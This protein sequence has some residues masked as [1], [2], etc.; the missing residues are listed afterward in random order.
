MTKTR[1]TKSALISSVVALLLCFA[2][3]V[4]STF[5]WFTDSVTS[6]NNIIKSGTLDVEM[7]WAEGTEDPATA[8]WEDASTTAIFDYDNWEP[9]YVDVKHVKISNV[10]TL[11][12]KYIVN[13]KANGEVSKLAE[14]IDVYF[15]DPAIQVSDRSA[16][17]DECKV[18]T[19]ADVLNGKVAP[20][21][22]DL[23]AAESDSITIALKMQE[24]AGNEYQNLS[25]GTN[26]SVQVLATQLASE[27]DSFNGEYDAGAVTYVKYDAA[28]T[29]A[30]NATALQ[31]A[32]D[33]ANEGDI[34]LLG[35]GNWYATQYKQFKINTDGVTLVGE[36][37]AVLGF[38]AENKNSILD[39]H[40][41]NVTIRN[42]E[43]NKNKQEFNQCILAIGAENL[44]VDSCTFYGENLDGGNTP[45]IGIY[46]FENLDMASDEANDEVTK[47]T[48]TNNNFLGAA[49]GTYKGGAAKVTTDPGVATAQVS[50]D[51]VIANNVFVG[52]N[53]LIENW[54]SWSKECTR[55]HEFVPTIE[56]NIFESPNLC[57][58]NTPHSIYLR[59][60]RQ[61]DPDK[62]LPADYMDNFV[63]DNTVATPENNTVVTYN[64]VDY[65]LNNNYGTFYRD[66]ATYGVIAYCY[67]QS[68]A[69]GE[70]AS[71]ASEL[72][73]AIDNAV[74]NADG[75]TT[76][77]ELTGDIVGDITVGQSADVKIVID[78]NGNDFDGSLVVDGKSAT[79]TSAGL[80]IQNVVFK[81]DS[82][83]TDACINLGNGTNATRY[84]CNVTIKNCTFDVPDA[85]G[86]K[87]YTGGDKNLTIIDCTATARAHSLAQLKGIDGILVKN[88]TIESV[89]GI[90]FNNSN[91]IVV[92]NC[93]IDV[94]K[95][96]VRFG[97]SDNSTVENY[98]IIDCTIAS[99]NVDDDAAIVLRAGATNANLTITNTTITAGTTMSGHENA[100][101]VIQ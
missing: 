46:I 93:T 33:N 82:I 41:D 92:E 54:R 25:I 50:E 21:Q 96:A 69:K 88:C 36:N 56:N 61:G 30:E 91:N 47:Y 65:V 51:M 83:D 78:G 55:D 18:G 15:V 10:G 40:G 52:A 72:Q 45:T 11:A 90:N 79:I 49:V 67:G 70:T 12:L 87:S 22:G 32:L 85:V 86:I 95:Y 39:V 64:G 60:Y 9:G 6:A 38:E 68:Y 48:I 101:V 84:T 98:E 62:I 23:L 27:E 94:Q 66:N 4:G 63:A 35:A 59:C 76:L 7:Y 99:D 19:L 8:V 74:A 3:L 29:V 97:E 37:G 26:F 2:M 80:T 34:I 42:I 43:F 73:A 31:T 16:L 53:I 77:I 1:S 100:N 81:A 58:A 17:I 89:R 71:N 28:K 20:A 13:I 14:V 44:T 57:F 24:S 75:D 5:A